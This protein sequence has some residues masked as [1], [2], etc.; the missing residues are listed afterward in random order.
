MRREQD[1]EIAAPFAPFALFGAPFG[2]C[3]AP[4]GVA[5]QTS[6][7]VFFVSF[8]LRRRKPGGTTMTTHRLTDEQPRSLLTVE[9][10]AHRLSIGRTTMFQLIKTG[11]VDSV[12]IGRARRVPIEALDAYVQLLST[13]QHAA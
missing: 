11:A 7:F 1:P 8:V 4:F 10:A 5:S 3:A 9:Q 2:H 13:Q 12:Q 6:K